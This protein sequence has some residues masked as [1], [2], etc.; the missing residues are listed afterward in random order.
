MCEP[1]IAYMLLTSLTC[2]GIVFVCWRG[3]RRA[4]QAKGIDE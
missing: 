2:I 4:R 3:Q 1:P